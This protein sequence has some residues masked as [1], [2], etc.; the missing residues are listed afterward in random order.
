MYNYVALYGSNSYNFKIE[1]V[2]CALLKLLSDIRLL[3][4]SKLCQIRKKNRKK[5]FYLATF[6]FLCL[7]VTQNQGRP[8]DQEYF[9]IFR[10]YHGLGRMMPIYPSIIRRIS[11]VHSHNTAIFNNFG[12]YPFSVK[13]NTC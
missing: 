11:P 3:G 12:K 6:L 2:L 10:H 13:V 9:N 1:S 8:S 4:L 7:T 5:M